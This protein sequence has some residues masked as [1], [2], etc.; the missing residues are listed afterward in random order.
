M[1]QKPFLKWVGGKSQII[2]KIMAKFPDTME[3]YHE[4]FLGG[5]SVLLALLSWQKENKITIKRHICAYDINKSLISVY[6]HVQ[7][8][9][10]LLYDAIIKIKNEYDRIQDINGNKKPTN[11]KEGLTSK[12]SY[13]YWMRIEYN[14]MKRHTIKRSAIFIFL[15]K[16]CFRGL[17]RENSGGKFNVPYGHYYNPNIIDKNELDNIS[18]LIKNVK[19]IH[20]DFTDSM[21]RINCGDFVYLDPPYAPKNKTSFVKYNGCGFDLEMHEKLFKKIHELNNKK[22]KFI[23]SNEKV[24]LVLDNFSSYKREDIIAKRA[25]NSK[26]PDSKTTEIIIYN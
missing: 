10:D 13:Y 3:N 19:F 25:I 23:M 11:K 8:K 9:K 6:N 21:K 15:N 4:I 17:Y 5:G 22:I 1:I 7:K 14:R 2:D 18:N 16:T 24:D 20:S 26:K 12:E